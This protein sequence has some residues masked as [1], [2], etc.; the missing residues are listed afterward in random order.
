MMLD[1]KEI[2]G[3]SVNERRDEESWIKLS[4]IDIA[5]LF[6][7]MRWHIYK[8]ISAYNSFQVYVSETVH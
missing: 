6:F 5:I 4:F 3:I 7:K 8:Y 2:I 1:D